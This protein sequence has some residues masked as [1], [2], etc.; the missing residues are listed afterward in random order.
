MLL[1]SATVSKFSERNISD[2]K[3]YFQNMPSV[4]ERIGA[5]FWWRF[6][7]NKGF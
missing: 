1:E 6:S 3:A 7:E 2:S 4:Q 5:E